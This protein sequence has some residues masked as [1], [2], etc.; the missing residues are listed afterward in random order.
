MYVLDTILVKQHFYLKSREKYM[1]NK[2][3]LNQELKNKHVSSRIALLS[4]E[5]PALLPSSPL[6]TDSQSNGLSQTHGQRQ[7]NESAL[8]VEEH[9]AEFEAMFKRVDDSK[10]WYLS[11]GNYQQL[12]KIEWTLALIKCS[13]TSCNVIHFLLREY[14]FGNM[15]RHHLE[16]WYQSHIWSMIEKC[17]DKV[18][19][20]EAV[21]GE[22]AS[23]GSKRRMNQNR[24][25][26]AIN[27]MPR[28]AYGHKCDLVFRQYDN[29]QN[30][31]L[32]VVGSE[33]KSRIEEQHGSNYMKEG[34]F[35]L[36]RMLKDML[37]VLL[38][39][40]EYDERT[41][42]IRNVGLLHSGLSCTMVEL[43]LPTAYISRVSRS[44]TTQISNCTSCSV[45]FL[46]VQRDRER[47]V[48]CCSQNPHK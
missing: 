11:T 40:V 34:F 33:A 17:F 42:E 14:E 18:H 44:Q 37:D 7:S 4:Q 28:L 31:P 24:T 8:V 36:P 21:I 1:E 29:D 19:G 27:S 15:D 48:K 38:K 35:K 2:S 12:R 43:D 39:K 16:Q 5:S 46:G 30:L 6:P 20:V 32:E 26:A 41:T 45:N 13:S 3:F 25:I 10:K 47:D 22:S 23:L 9:S